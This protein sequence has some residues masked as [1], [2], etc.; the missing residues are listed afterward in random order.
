MLTYKVNFGLHR[1]EPL[2]YFALK[3]LEAIN[4]IKNERKAQ[5]INLF[6]PL[7]QSEQVKTLK[8]M[9]AVYWKVIQWYSPQKDRVTPGKSSVRL[10]F[11]QRF[12]KYMASSQ[13][14]QKNSMVYGKNLSGQKPCQNIIKNTP[15]RQ[16]LF[17]HVYAQYRESNVI[18]VKK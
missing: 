18:E 5:Y 7:Q 17:C 14:Q 1:F 8:E 4:H 12:F 9:V 6:Y 3:I 11:Y 16:H 2:N 15:I 13:Q 10:K